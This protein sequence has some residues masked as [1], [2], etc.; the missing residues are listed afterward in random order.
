MLTIKMETFKKRKIGMN[1]KWIKYKMKMKA[2]DKNNSS[3]SSSNLMLK[4]SN[5][6]ITKNNNISSRNS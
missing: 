5:I 4:D 6:S 3:S 1:Q 2:K